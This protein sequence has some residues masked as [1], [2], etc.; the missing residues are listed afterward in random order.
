M[1]NT[2]NLTLP[3]ITLDEYVDSTPLLKANDKRVLQKL[4]KF[5]PEESGLLK[6]TYIGMG[7]MLDL[8]RRTI[9]TCLQKLVRKKF[10]VYHNKVLKPPCNYRRRV[11][12]LPET[13]PG[14]KRDGDAK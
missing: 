7:R 10:L 12:S 2:I 14:F 6:I 3:S 13:F 8:D 5:Q 11:Y 4:L 1:N 9:A